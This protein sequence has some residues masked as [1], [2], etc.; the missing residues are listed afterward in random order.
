MTQTVSLPLWLFLLILLFFRSLR[1]ALLSLIPNLLPLVLV[2]AVMALT[3]IPLK[4]GTSIV[5]S[6]VFGIAVD[7]TVHFL[8]AFH[9][10]GGRGRAAVLTT[11]LK[12]KKHRPTTLNSL[13]LLQPVATGLKPLLAAAGGGFVL[14]LVLEVHNHRPI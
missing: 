1:L 3:G 6:I 14:Q 4:L 2:G 9:H 10:N 13:K 12:V 7:D 5:F 11:T 8:A